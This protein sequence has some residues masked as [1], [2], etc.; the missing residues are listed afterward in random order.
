MQAYSQEHLD[1]LLREVDAYFELSGDR[2]SYLW[3]LTNVPLPFG[4][5]RGGRVFGAGKST[6]T[7]IDP[8]DGRKPGKLYYNYKTARY[9]VGFRP[10]LVLDTQLVT[11]LRDY[12]R[13]AETGEDRLG[14]PLRG[15]VESFL[16]FVVEEN[17]DFNPFFYYIES[18]VKDIS[19]RFEASAA[20]AA[21]AVLKL[22]SMDREE[23]LRGGRVVVDE[24]QLAAYRRNFGGAALEETALRRSREMSLGLKGV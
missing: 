4:P 15:N 3:A 17:Y 14:E 1:Q 18:V 5:L 9:D 21:V 11:Y 7:V 19:G 16:R 10:M 6:V 13:W 24:G 22:Q 23:F 12:V 20:A 8:F 2:S